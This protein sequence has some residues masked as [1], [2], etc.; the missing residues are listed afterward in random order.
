MIPSTP[1]LALAVALVVSLLTLSFSPAAAQDADAPSIAEVAADDGRFTTLVAALG[2][3]GLADTFSDCEGGPFTVL[4]PTDDAFTAALT[5]LNLEVGDLIADADLLTSILTYHVIEGA[6][7]SSAVLGLDGAFAPTLQGENVG[8]AVDGETI[9]IT[10]GN[11]TSAN[12]VLPDV[13]ACNGIIHAIDNVLLPPSV[14]G[15]LG[16]GAEDDGDELAVTGTSSLLLT[17]IAGAMLA[18]GALAV[19]SS[20]RLRLDV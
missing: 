9:S 1:R 18:A 12:V 5:A 4:A 7:P 2:A 11:P 8:V 16:L 6:V 17:L 3:A 20:R 13:Q 15:A 10:N 14:A 19:Y